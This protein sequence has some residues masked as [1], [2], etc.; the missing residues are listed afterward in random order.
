MKQPMETFLFLLSICGAAQAE[1]LIYEGTLQ[2]APP[3]AELVFEL[4][5]GNACEAVPA[6]ALQAPGG[7]PFAY[8]LTFPFERAVTARTRL[9]VSLDDGGAIAV[10]VEQRLSRR[11]F[12]PAL[13]PTPVGDDGMRRVELT[14]DCDLAADDPDALMFASITAALRWLA[15]RRIPEGWRARISV[16]NRCVFDEALQIHHSDG[17][18]LEI[19]G[20]TDPNAEERVALI[21]SDSDGVVVDQDHQL[22][23][24]S[25][26]AI[27]HLVEGE[28][29]EHLGLLASHGGR[30]W[31]A[32]LR[33]AG[34]DRGY[35]ARNG[36]W[37]GR[38]DGEPTL[39]A[40]GNHHGFH[41]VADG[42][43]YL[44]GAIAENNLG[45][46]FVAD[47][48]SY[49]N[50]STAIATGSGGLGFHAL[51]HSFM[52][53]AG[54]RAEAGGGGFQSALNSGMYAARSQAI[55]NAGSGY[56]ASEGGVIYAPNS[57]AVD[58]RDGGNGAI[59]G[60]F[61]GNLSLVNITGA[62]AEVC[63]NGT[64]LETQYASLIY[65]AAANI[66]ARP[67][68]DEQFL[69]DGPVFIPNHF[70]WISR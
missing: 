70:G 38:I 53:V 8:E 31:A 25:G 41:A 40:S 57:R 58:N 1:T 21:F 60:V 54:A 12:E 6:L 56:Y 29:R 50:A 19:V 61:A 69:P 66:C 9:R 52:S 11:L 13:P 16:P 22:G 30:I 5:E 32:D 37:I 42:T 67:A 26:L 39:E 4:C 36:G 64:D 24:L 46:G 23:R 20:R 7:G 65:A 47:A 68:V 10:L 17:Q 63:G 18:R 34:F 43:M 33:V 48:G 28:E 62:D 44:W 55:E 15:P 2:G 35:Q 14:A 59:R 51:N 45:K 3:G 49:I 27:T